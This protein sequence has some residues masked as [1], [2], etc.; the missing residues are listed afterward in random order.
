M[1]IDTETP[2]SP[3]WWFNI[4]AGQLHDR[5]V[6]REGRRRWSR[7]GV[8]SSRVRPGLLLLDDYRRGDPPLHQ[9]VHGGWAE[10]FRRYVRMGRLNV[11]DLL[12]AAPSN[13]MGIRDF[14]TAAADDELGDQD[15]RTL[16]RANDLRLKA[17]DVHE[18][19]LG[20]G[21]GYT[22][23]TPPDSTRDYSLI[24]A[25]SPLQC[26]TAHDA[27]TGETLAGLKV[28]RDDWD[29]ADFAYLFLP[30]ELW[31]ARLDGPTSIKRRGPFVFSE[32]WAW[33][34]D[35]FD[36]VPD[37]QVAMIRFQNRD[38]VGEFEH[39]LDTL[40]R[41]NDK[42]FNEWWISKIQAFRQRAIMIPDEDTDD[43]PGA[44]GDADG[45]EPNPLYDDDASDLA[46]IFTSA[47]DA[48][49]RL[50]KDAKIWESTPVDTRPL[51]DS[52]KKDLEHLA[53][54][55]MN[56][57]H[58]IT[59]DAASGSA[60]GASLMR[61]EH[62]YKIEDRRDRADGGW[63]RTVAMAFRFQG[64]TARANVSQIETLWGPI[65]RYSLQEKAGAAS[66]LAQTLPSEAIWTDVLQYPPAEVVDR[67]RALR[68]RDL[69]YRTPQTQQTGRPAGG[70]GV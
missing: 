66:Q 35:R 19:M 59:P 49:W 22:I 37:N 34:E 13:R 23:V 2:R 51:I 56:P 15:A 14:R 21:A 42:L 4:L 11:A 40:D 6:G 32:K 64:D 36:D 63:A 7:T 29:A 53:A 62:V 46:G 68:N 69:L 20:L 44:T 12:V 39:H 58:T 70:S 61:E 50:P 10:P 38:G 54:V 47:P 26:I 1:P 27:A 33:D 52:V 57:L 31:V 43:E 67:L 24:T 8:D 17:R 48:M 30:G 60:E 3:G 9:D 45:D 18:Y 5:R 65:E 41:I 16:M 28:F 25:E 55:T